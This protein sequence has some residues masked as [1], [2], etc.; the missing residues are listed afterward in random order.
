MNKTIKYAKAVLLAVLCLSLSLLFVACGEKTQYT[1]TFDAGA[2]YSIQSQQITEGEQATRPDDPERFGFKIVKWKNGSTEWDF[3]SPVTQ[4]VTLV[5]EWKQYIFVEDGVITECIPNEMPAEL[6]IPGSINTI[7][8]EVFR[9]CNNLEKVVVS[10][11]VVTLDD[12]A[13]FCCNNLTEVTL[14]DSV[15]SVGVSAFGMCGKLERAVLSNSLT[16]I[17]G[18]LF[19]Q[20]GNLTSITIPDGVTTIGNSAFYNCN[21][22]TSLAIPAGV[23]N[24]GDGAFSNCTSLVTFTFGENSQ[25]TSIGSNAFWGCSAITSIT[26]PA[27]VTTVGQN[28]FRFCDK[29]TINCKALSQPSGWD[30]AWNSGNRPV[31]WGV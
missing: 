28:A 16:E 6:T 21:K 4:N 29:L 14:P 7:G 19:D 17:S 22:M 24:I 27:S 20:C 25:I 31:N 15:T 11:G 8:E 5:A 10:S 2:E 13:F 3:S 9:S 30:T 26:I 12:M 1:V 23:Q 18:A